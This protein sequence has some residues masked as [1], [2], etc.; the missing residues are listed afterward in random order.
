M[1]FA[2]S[3][4]GGFPTQATVGDAH[5]VGEGAGVFAEFLGVF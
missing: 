4:L 5:A 3:G 2:Q 1:G